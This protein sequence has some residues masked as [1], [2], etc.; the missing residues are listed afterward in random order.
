MAGEIQVTVIGN[1][2]SDPEL[3]FTAGGQAVAN[4]TIAQTPRSF[5]R[6]TNQWQDD[7]TMWVR[8]T[9]WGEMGENVAQ[10]LMKGMRVIATGGLKAKTFETKDGQQ[11]T[12]WEL[13]A[14][15]IAPSLRWATAQVQKVHR[16]HN[17]SSSGFPAQNNAQQSP[18]QSNDPWQN[19]QYRDQGQ[20]L[21]Q[22]NQPP[23]QTNDVWGGGQQ[24]S[25]APP[26]F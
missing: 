9:V 13:T 7:E 23:L 2:V 8:T 15:E 24:Q 14:D 22:Q 5:N 25:D 6:Q 20:P 10:S 1:L 19:S 11:R 26:P 3:R 21:A 18:A 17:G 4:L 16:N 12:N